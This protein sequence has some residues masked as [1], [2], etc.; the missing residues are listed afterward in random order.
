M[1]LRNRSS[2][3][4]PAPTISRN[5]CVVYC[6]VSSK[7]Q[8]REGFSIPAQRKL[9]SEYADQKGLTIIHEF[10]EAETAKEAGRTA[11]NKMVAFL[12]ETPSCRIIL[13]EKTDRLYRNFRDL[14]TV[15]ELGVTVHFV[16][17]NTILSADSRSSEKLMH[18]IK[19]AIARNY[20]DNLSEEVKKGL[21]E[22]AE[23]GHF[24]GVAHV[25]YVNN[26]VTRRIDIDPVRGP[27]MARVFELYASGE[28]S[29]KALTVKA[30]EIGLRHS[31]GDR[32]MTKSELHRLLKNPIYVGNFRWLGKVHSGSHEPLVSRE[33]FDRVQELMEGKGVKRRGHRKHLHP[34]MGLLKCGLCGCRMTAERKKGKYVYYRCTGFKGTCGNEYIREEKLAALLGETI[35]SVQ[36]TADVAADIATAIRQSEGDAQALRTTALQ[37]VDKRRRTVVSKIDR[38]YEDFVS[39]RISE[40]F[41]TRKSAEWEAELQTIDAERGRLEAIQVPAV[42]T[43]QKILELAE[44]AEI[45]YKSQNPG[46][47][48]RLLET[49]LS[50]CTF[51]R[52]TLCPTYTSPFDLLV[53]GNETG[54][55]RRERDSNPE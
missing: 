41:W 45:L 12:K 46:E 13:V 20:V 37:Q 30:Y 9:L 17:E 21:R 7:D 52:G 2:A 3:E 18:N 55:W 34:F 54:N 53:K 11:F 6:R 22:K 33:T 47:Q 28:Y 25:G 31:R 14:L 42:A 27:L 29:L 15:E 38:G 36:I 48:R 44:R 8:E 16:K 23:Q 49:V 24:P 51:D 50:N 32:R 1:K 39:D 4:S 10:K 40:A 35:K 43:A 26:R 5:R 19:V